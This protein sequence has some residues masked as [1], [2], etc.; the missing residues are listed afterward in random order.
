MS[1]WAVARFRE[2]RGAEPTGPGAAGR[3]PKDA[4]Q[5]M[6]DAAVVSAPGKLILM[7]EHAAVY[8]R[9]AL[10]AAVGPGLRL[11]LGRRRAGGVVI[12]LPD[13]GFRG[14]RSWDEIMARTESVRA[15]WRRY[16]TSPT[17][18][19]FAAIR[20]GAVD[21]LVTLALGETA[22]DLGARSLPALRLRIESRLP[23]G[24]GFGSSAAAAAAVAAGLS[25]LLG[26]VA[27]DG[28]ID[29]VAL[30]VE[31]R[32][33]GLPSGVDHKTVLR[34][35]VIWARRAPDGDL[36]IT[37][38]A[39]RAPIL[40]RLRVFQTGRPRETTGEVVAAVRRRLEEQ[41]VAI[42]TLLERMRR[43]VERLRAELLTAR[44]APAKVAALI[45]DYEICLEELGVVPRPV[46]ETI[47][48]IEDAG[49]AAK[50]SGAG[51]L[52][53]S[54]AGCLL[55]YGGGETVRDLLTR[56]PEYRELPV[57]LGVQGLRVEKRS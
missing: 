25:A 53:G 18:A 37:A 29:R 55:V 57:E 30:A 5:D 19:G 24:S 49:G 46:R 35:G 40:A 52:S 31:Q 12:D 26:G 41:P 4:P 54:A 44:E 11:S 48:R 2:R 45:R 13:L 28:R 32:L 38:L 36:R 15:A 50:I 8:G 51:A 56:V 47:R 39:P 33:H 22:D 17:P 6:S 10:V 7:G 34:G 16:A 23:V 21:E 3:R 1:D 9:P 20:S 42:E 27:D 14:E 43:G